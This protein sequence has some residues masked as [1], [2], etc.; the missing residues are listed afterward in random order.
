MY[1]SEKSS[2][3]GRDHG[4]HHHRHHQHHSDS[5][6]DERSSRRHRER[7]VERDTRDVSRQSISATTNVFCAQCGNGDCFYDSSCNQC[8][9]NQCVTVFPDDG[10]RYDLTY[11]I[12]SVCYG[13]VLS[14]PN[15]V[16]LPF[17]LTPIVTDAN[18]FQLAPLS[19][20]TMPLLQASFGFDANTRVGQKVLI[21][22]FEAP[23]NTAF[24][25]IYE[26]TALPTT[27]APWYVLKRFNAVTPQSG[28]ALGDFVQVFKGAFKL[29]W[30]ITEIDT[31][32]TPHSFMVAPTNYDQLRCYKPIW[33]VPPK[34]C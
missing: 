31:T 5:F 12:A 9:C 6:D 3:R 25:T 21:S 26:I 33:A 20:N 30:E 10:S 28:L 22:D 27:T 8:G 11:E 7:S 2:S 16:P 4:H 17:T 29:I 1:S 19:P 13:Y 23:N 32:T 34:Q 18:Q 24:N 15:P 14:I